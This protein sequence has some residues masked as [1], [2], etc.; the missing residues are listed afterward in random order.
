MKRDSF[1][2]Y[3]KIN[4]VIKELTDEQKGKVFQAILDYEETGDEPELDI[5]LR[6][7]F[8]PIKQDLDKNN[9]KWENQ[10]KSRSEAGK[11]GMASRYKKG[12]KNA[13]ADITEDNKPNAVNSVITEDKTVITNL[14]NVTDNVYV[15]DNVYVND[16]EKELKDYCPEPK[17][18]GPVI[19][20]P[21]NDKSEYPVNEGAVQEWAE[22]YP[23]VDVIQQ[24]RSMKGWLNANPTRRKTKS[25]IEK[26]INGWL[27]KEQNQGGQGRAAPKPKKEFNYEQREWDFDE[28]EKIKRAELMKAAGTEE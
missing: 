19:T 9:E 16:N 24:L 11:K 18:A 12:E 25:G 22:L 6:L 28:L 14:T 13:E 21:L 27:A 2:L 20:L 7:V 4:E 5:L 10:T 8:I 1:V 23:A 15:D 3:T 26:F 17:A